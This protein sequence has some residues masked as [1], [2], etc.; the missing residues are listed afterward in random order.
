MNKRT[1]LHVFSVDQEV[2]HAVNIKTILTTIVR[3]RKVHT[4]KIGFHSFT[5]T[6]DRQIY[7]NR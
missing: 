3:Y 6:T 1:C 4:C 2:T 5:K 7:P